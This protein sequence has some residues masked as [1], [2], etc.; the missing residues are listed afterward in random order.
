MFSKGYSF[1][2]KKFFL[3]FFIG[4]DSFYIVSDIL[5]IYVIILKRLRDN[6]FVFLGNLL[7]KINWRGI[8]SGIQELWVL[9]PVRKE[10]LK[11]QIMESF[12]RDVLDNRIGMRALRHLP[13]EDSIDVMS[14]FGIDRCHE[15]EECVRDPNGGFEEQASVVYESRLNFMADKLSERLR[16]KIERPPRL[17][18]LLA[19]IEQEAESDS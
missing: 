11:D 13:A 14:A 19:L 8:F 10:S 17:N 16:M 6:Q 12:R 15:I 4:N 1:F 2:Q 3:F 9:D 5:N 7:R 18:I